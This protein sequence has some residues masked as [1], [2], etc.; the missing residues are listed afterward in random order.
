MVHPV[1]RSPDASLRQLPLLLGGAART[2]NGAGAGRRIHSWQLARA[3]RQ[4]WR[5]DPTQS[6]PYLRARMLR[7]HGP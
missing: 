3:P 6:I 4:L 5:Q 1:P 7:H 2:T